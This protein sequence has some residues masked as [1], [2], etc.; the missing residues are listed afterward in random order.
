MAT[1]L[2]VSSS[3]DLVR[4]LLTRLGENPEREGL[5]NTPERYVQ[6]M[7][8]LTSGYQCDLQ[9][10]L[11][12]A[13]FTVDYDEMVIV[14]DIEVYSLCEHHLL[15][16]FGRCHVAYL[17]KGKVLGLSKIPRLVDAFARRLQVQERLTTQIAET[18]QEWVKPEGVGVVVEAQHL[19]MMMR[20]VE[21]QNSSAVTSHMLGTFRTC[22]ET[23]GEFLSL[24]RGRS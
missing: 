2:A 22:A 14:R 3:Q 9:A 6:A 5:A 12:S 10:L 8:Y 15:P 23:R 20:G 1:D 19:C 7:G 21:K 13:L 18:I 11:T 16:F 24:I 17:P 4:S